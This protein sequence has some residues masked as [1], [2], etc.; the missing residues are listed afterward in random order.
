MR[1]SASKN[2]ENK[3]TGIFHEET[4][5]VSNLIISLSMFYPSMKKEEKE[6]ITDTGGKIL[7]ASADL[8]VCQHNLKTRC[9]ILRLALRGGLKFTLG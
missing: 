8:H 9:L 4:F 5:E 3:I 2:R 6:L 1:E 7:P